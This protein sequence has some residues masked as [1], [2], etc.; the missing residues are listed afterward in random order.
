M[1]VS[2]K[3]VPII[4]AGTKRHSSTKNAHLGSA[5][6]QQRPLNLSD[7]KALGF[8]HGFPGDGQ[9]EGDAALAEGREAPWR[10]FWAR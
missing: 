2:R 6:L 3:Q 8:R 5:L 1:M 4:L 10:N 7:R 9:E